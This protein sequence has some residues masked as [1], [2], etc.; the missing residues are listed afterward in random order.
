ME[1]WD[2]SWE[3]KQ[4]SCECPIHSIHPSVAL[5]IRHSNDMGGEANFSSFHFIRRQ[6]TKRRRWTRRK[7]NISF[8]F[9]GIFFLFILQEKSL[10]LTHSFVL[11]RSLLMTMMIKETTHDNGISF[12]FS[13]TIAAIRI[14]IHSSGCRSFSLSRSRSRR[15]TNG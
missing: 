9:H 2:I 15:R 6:K 11:S 1:T 13:I 4:N 7:G 8:H 5:V 14:S 3:A 10:P 12:H